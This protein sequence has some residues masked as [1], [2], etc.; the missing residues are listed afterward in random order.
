MKEPNPSWLLQSFDDVMDAKGVLVLV[1]AVDA[2]ARVLDP[3][4]DHLWHGLGSEI[5]AAQV[6][7]PVLLFPLSW[8]ASWGVT[9][10]TRSWARRETWGFRGG[11]WHLSIRRWRWYGSLGWR[12]LLLNNGCGSC[13]S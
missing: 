4:V 10:V 3:G 9:V 1:D 7:H 11:T 12:G 6:V 2:G 5:S 13:L 8:G